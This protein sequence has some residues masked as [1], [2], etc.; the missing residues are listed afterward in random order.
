[1]AYDNRGVG[2]YKHLQER[3]AVEKFS[4][5]IVNLDEEIAQE[6]QSLCKKPSGWFLD[7][8]GIKNRFLTILKFPD[9]SSGCDEVVIN[10]RRLVYSVIVNMNPQPSIKLQTYGHEIALH[11]IKGLESMDCTIQAIEIHLF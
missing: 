8:S 7:T 9:S 2:V 10:G 6:I 3:N 11:Q 4:R 5:K 1:M